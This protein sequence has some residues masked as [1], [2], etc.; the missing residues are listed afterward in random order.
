MKHLVVGGILWLAGQTVARQVIS[1]VLFVALGRMLS[2]EDFGVVSLSASV[3]L[4]LQ[5]FS[6]QGIAQ[7]V[8]QRSDLTDSD[9]EVAYTFNLLVCIGL[10][11]LVILCSVLFAIA[12]PEHS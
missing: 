8:I 11:G 2:P 12:F 7:A 9:A 5:T 3:I 10:A 4:I 1:F 6:S